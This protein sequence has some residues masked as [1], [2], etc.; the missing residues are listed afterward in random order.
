MAKK[1]TPI[2]TNEMSSRD[3]LFFSL[4][5]MIPLLVAVVLTILYFSDVS[6]N[7]ATLVSLIV[8]WSIF[9]TNVGDGFYFVILVIFVSQGTIRNYRTQEKKSGLDKIRKRRNQ[10]SA[11]SFASRPRA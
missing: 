10:K 11:T 6:K 8:F 5:F 9:R 4:Q 1:G 7:T 3:K 2:I